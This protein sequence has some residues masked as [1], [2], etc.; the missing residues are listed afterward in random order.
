MFFI[1]IFSTTSIGFSQSI[2]FRESPWL[3]VA[4]TP[5]KNRSGG[6][7]FLLFRHTKYSAMWSKIYAILYIVQLGLRSRI[8]FMM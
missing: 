4:H 7:R 3:K 2:T 8:L 5:K 1:I 6:V